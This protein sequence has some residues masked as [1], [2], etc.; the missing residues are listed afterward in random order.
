MAAVLA[1]A[2]NVR[3]DILNE[4]TH[5]QNV[6]TITV[7]PRNYKNTTLILHT[8]GDHYHAVRKVGLHNIHVSTTK[9]HQILIRLPEVTAA[10]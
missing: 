4:A 1:N 10:L 2:F 5:H 3:L 9:V 6:E 7:S 8:C